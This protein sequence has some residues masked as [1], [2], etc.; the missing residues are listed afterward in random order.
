MEL[1]QL[2][3]LIEKEEILYWDFK[4]QN[5]YVW[6]NIDGYSIIYEGDND[7]WLLRRYREDY[8][9]AEWDAITILTNLARVRWL[10]ERTVRGCKW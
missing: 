8:D 6:N 10:I 9:L 4:S 5:I 2:D 7:I 1:K 3:D